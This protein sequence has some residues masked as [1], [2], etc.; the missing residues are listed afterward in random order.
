MTVPSVWSKSMKK[1]RKGWNGGA[2]INRVSEINAAKVMKGKTTQEFEG[3]DLHGVKESGE[4]RIRKENQEPSD[5]L[6]NY[7]TTTNPTG[8]TVQQKKKAPCDGLSEEIKRRPRKKVT[9]KGPPREMLRKDR[10]AGKR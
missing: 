6:R 4:P 2:G 9:A 7:H 1:R 3:S 5:V 8:G 10:G